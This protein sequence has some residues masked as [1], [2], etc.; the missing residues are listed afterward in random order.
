MNTRQPQT[1]PARAGTG[2]TGLDDI[3]GGG[4]P[5]NRLYLIL[6]PPGTGKSTLGLQFLLEGWRLGE[7]VLY[8]SLSQTKSELQQ[9]A[10]SH[11]W[12][13]QGVNIIEFPTEQA[14]TRKDKLQTVFH[15][16]DVDL[17]AFL[18]ELERRVA[19]ADPDRI[20]L[21]SFTEFRLLARDELRYRQTMLD[22]KL[23]LTNLPATTLLLDDD[24]AQT[25]D[26]QVQNLTNGVIALTR[27]SPDYGHLRRQVQ[28]IKMRGIAFQDGFHDFRI[29]SG[30]V[31]VYP[32]LSTDRSRRSPG[33]PIDSG[34]DRLDA[35][36]GGGL[37]PGTSALILGPSG[38]GKSSLATLFAVSAARKGQ[39]AALFLFEEGE[40]SFIARSN[41]LGMELGRHLDEGSIMLRRINVTELAP[42]EFAQAV[43]RS[44]TESRAAVVIIDSIAGYMN[45]MPQEKLL[46]I[47]LH[48]LVTYLTQQGALAILVMAEHGL[49]AATVEAPIDVSFRADSVLLLRY[50]EQEGRLGKTV[51]VVKKRHGRHDPMIAAL[52]FEGGRIDVA[53]PEPVV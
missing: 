45:A 31:E 12:S 2:V 50:T 29:R 7:R 13:L 24:P 17:T 1:L 39:R 34:I 38:V 19:A 26:F 48:E 23:F 40:S 15:S 14:A 20:V 43:Q 28:V 41:A 32:R 16:A 4:L 27:H 35:M 3:L 22:L 5:R 44:V 33:A 11:G 25:G 18:D 52:K 49:L 10:E 53:L 30:G 37:E 51:T 42:N 9:I 6:G 46:L 47:Q 36:L 21:D 8:I